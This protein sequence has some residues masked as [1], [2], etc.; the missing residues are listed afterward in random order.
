LVYIVTIAI[1]IDDRT[2][3]VVLSLINT[4]I[5][6]TAVI[7]LFALIS[8]RQYL[9]RKEHESKLEWLVAERTS[10][11]QEA[12]AQRDTMLQEI[13]H[14][15]GNSLQL[16][17]SFVSLQQGEVDDAHRQVLKETELRVHAIADVHATLYSHQRLAYLP[18]RDYANELIS[19]MKIAYRG[20]AEIEARV[21]VEMDAHID[22]AISFGIV[23]NELITNATK[24]ATNGS[25]RPRMRVDLSE[26]DTELVLLVRDLGPGFSRSSHKGVGTEVVDQLVSQNQG[27]ITRKTVDGALVTVRFPLSSVLRRDQLPPGEAHSA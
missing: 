15:V 27:Q 6:A 1:G 23:L 2:A 16:L 13:H 12:L 26:V 19:D 17:A 5:L 9:I 24:H 18:L 21:D 7:V 11:L 3:S 8:Y 22:F 4:M 25:S 10:E 14:R 20:D